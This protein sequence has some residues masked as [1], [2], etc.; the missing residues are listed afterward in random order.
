MIWTP[1]KLIPNLQLGDLNG[2]W[3]FKQAAQMAPSPST[4]GRMRYIVSLTQT[5]TTSK[6]RTQVLVKTRRNCILPTLLLGL[7]QLPWKT[8]WQFLRLNQEHTQPHNS[9]PA[10]DVKA[11]LHTDLYKITEDR[12]KEENPRLSANEMAHKM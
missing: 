8:A 9:T 2:A 7:E 6:H 4:H 11:Q 12:Q 5:Q 1:S 10:K 3:H